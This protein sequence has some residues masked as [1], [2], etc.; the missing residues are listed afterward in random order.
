MKGNFTFKT[1]VEIFLITFAVAILLAFV[2]KNITPGTNKAT[3]IQ[4]KISLCEQY[5]KYD[6]NCNDILDSTEGSNAE[7]SID[8]NTDNPASLGDLYKNLDSVCGQLGTPDIKTC[9]DT[10]CSD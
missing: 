4:K 8:E 5:V 6:S 7:I 2:W 9:C 1:A 3:L 10:F